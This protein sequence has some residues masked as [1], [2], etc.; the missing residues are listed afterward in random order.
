ML[1]KPWYSAKVDLVGLID[2]PV[3]DDV[4]DVAAEG[5]E[6]AVTRLGEQ[7]VTVGEEEDAFFD[8]GFPEPPDDIESRVG[9]AGAGGHDE[10]DTVLAGRDRLDSPVDGVDLVVARAL[11]GGVGIIRLLDD[12]AD[13]LFFQTLDARGI[14][15]K[16]WW[17]RGSRRVRSP[18]RC[19]SS[20]L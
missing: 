3:A 8:T 15:S 17:G 13:L 7:L 10:Q 6:I 12:L 9:F 18:S 5:G 1:V 16:A 11:A 2:L 4:H 19:P 20:Y 14:Y